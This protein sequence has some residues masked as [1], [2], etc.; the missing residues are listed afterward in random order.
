M[1]LA[2]ATTRSSPRAGSGISAVRISPA[3]GPVTQKAR[4]ISVT[5]DALDQQVRAEREVAHPRPEGTRERRDL[6]ELQAR[7]AGAKD[8]RCQRDLQPV[9]RARRQKARDRNAATF[10]QDPVEPTSRE[11]R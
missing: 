10:D 5:K 8:H 1:P 6:R 2:T 7:P 3:P 4:A 11:R 9:E